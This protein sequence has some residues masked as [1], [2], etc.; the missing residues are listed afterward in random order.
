MPAVDLALRLWWYLNNTQV[1]GLGGG[2]TWDAIGA[3]AY[4]LFTVWISSVATLG[5]RLVWWP[6]G[7]LKT[8]PPIYAR[9]L[10]LSCI[11]MHCHALSCQH[12]ARVIK[13]CTEHAGK[14]Q[15]VNLPQILRGHLS[16]AAFPASFAL[17]PLVPV[18]AELV[19]DLIVA[20]GLFCPEA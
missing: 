20:R 8:L 19:V 16:L 5:K 12:W 15:N 10:S 18:Q 3:T 2:A 13:W 11:V 14:W 7:C 6:S 9:P 17:R 4:G 1:A